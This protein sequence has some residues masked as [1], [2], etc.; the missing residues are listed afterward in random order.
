[1]L[2]SL[3]KY[4]KIARIVKKYIMTNSSLLTWWL[5]KELTHDSE[6]DPNQFSIQERIKGLLLS[7]QENNKLSKSNSKKICKEE[8]ENMLDFVFAVVDNIFQDAL[9][10]LFPKIDI[11]SP[12]IDM[13][14]E[15][16]YYIWKHKIEIH[17]WNVNTNTIQ[18]MIVIAHEYW[19]AIISEL[20]KKWILPS[21]PQVRYEE[22]F[23]DFLAWFCLRRYHQRFSTYDESDITEGK[24]TMEDL[25]KIS[26]L[27]SIFLNINNDMIGDTLG[28]KYRIPKEK[29]K[30]HH[31]TGPQ[32]KK[33][34]EDWYNSDDS[35]FIIALCKL[36]T[37]PQSEKLKNKFMRKNNPLNKK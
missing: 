13:W 1:M 34:F 22:Q 26:E 15:S 6:T 4:G 3:V 37:L 31:W 14:E 29:L 7:N 12:S 36:I 10:K 16:C 35:W 9:N 17:E 18:L 19:H 8:I 25:W 28:S 20:C 11:S 24:E 21:K 2:R 27:S 5:P 30:N 23:C 32:R 33:R